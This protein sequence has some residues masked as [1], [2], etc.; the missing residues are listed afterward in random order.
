MTTQKRIILA[1]GSPRRRELLTRAGLDFEIIPSPAEEL[2]DEQMPLHE[3]CEINAKLKALAVAREHP[4]AIVIGADTLVSIDQLP[5]GKPK[6][7]ADARAMLR[8]LAGRTQEVCTGVC[9]AV[10]ESTQSFHVITEVEFKPLTDQQ[11]R[12]YMKKVNV[13]DKAGAYAAQEYRELIIQEIRGDYDN[14]VGLPV[15]QV[16]E[17]IAKL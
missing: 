7:E 10:G 13:M 17:R 8:R 12:D 4:D 14:V 5:L 6:D 1:S 11:I 3:L 16:L 2:H 9:L 15:Q